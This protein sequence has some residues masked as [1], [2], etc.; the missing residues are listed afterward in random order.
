MDFV[1]KPLLV[2]AGILLPGLLFA[3]AFNVGVLRVVGS[4]ASIKQILTDSGIY[5]SVIPGVLDQAKKSTSGGNEV[6]LTDPAVKAAAESSFTN[7]VVQDST[8]KIIDGTYD[9]LN[10]KSPQPTF[11]ID[12]T[13]VKA[14]F[15]Q[16]VGEAATARAQTL[17]ACPTATLPTSFDPLNASCLPKD[18]APAQVGVQAK[19]NILTGQGFLE[20]PVI[21][22]DSAKSQESN[23][24]IFSKDLKNAPGGYQR[25]K[26]APFI[27][28]SLTLLAILAIIFLSVTR[29]KGLRHVGKTLVVTGVIMMVF[30]W[31]LNQVV[32][33]NLVP[34]IKFDN[35]VLQTNVRKLASDIA[36]SVDKNYWLFGGVYAVSGA[37]AIAGAMF[38]NKAGKEPV[39]VANSH[40]AVPAAPSKPA[41]PKPKKSVKIQG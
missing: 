32:T 3:T 26:A 25:A 36:G 23:Q 17:P 31:G 20:N 27:L 12:L 22:A 6:S 39:A 19:N 15:A 35:K 7:K 30:A 34:G 38:I 24:S 16:K 10:G 9:W 28:I 14:T 29:Q 5:S 4:P 11:N 8:E 2:L 37:L 13:G 33:R 41:P 1:R 40:S 21:N 18:I